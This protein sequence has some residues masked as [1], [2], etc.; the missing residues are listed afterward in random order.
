MLNDSSHSH[1]HNRVSATKADNNRRIH[2]DFYD[3]NVMNL[4]V[5]SI[6]ALNSYFQS[7]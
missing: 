5:T 3:W 1:C 6:L 4:N 2:L 7:I